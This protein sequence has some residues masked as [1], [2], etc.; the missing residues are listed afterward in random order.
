MY[1]V[2]ADKFDRRPLRSVLLLLSFMCSS[3]GVDNVRLGILVLLPH[4]HDPGTGRRHG[5]GAV[6]RIS[7]PSA[8]ACDVIRTDAR[9]QSTN[10][11]PHLPPT[12]AIS[13]AVRS[14]VARCHRVSTMSSP[15]R[16]AYAVGDVCGIHLRIYSPDVPGARSIARGC[17][18]GGVK[19]IGG[20]SSFPPGERS[21]NMIG[22]T[23]VLYGYAVR[24]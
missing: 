9:M 19:I 22:T 6:A 7:S 21:I 2:L 20:A 18:A 4:S 8:R 3:I 13:R 15:S 14:A 17:S 23:V 24:S 11:R 12:E 1:A 16:R 5:N 10:K